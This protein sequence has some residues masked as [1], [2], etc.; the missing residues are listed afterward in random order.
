MDPG[1]AREALR[2]AALDEDEGAD[3]LMV[4]PALAY[5][6][7]IARVRAASTLPLGAYNV[8]G[9]Y[10]MIKAAA[11]GGHDRRAPRG[12]RA[13]HVDPARRRRLHPD[14]P[15]DRRRSAFIDDAPRPA[16]R[17]TS[18]AFSASVARGFGLGADD[19]G[20]GLRGDL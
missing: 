10:A 9:E 12:A 20:L 14:V 6:D 3:M 17:M 2:E 7:V 11:R 1:N 16:G 13:A 8:S 4:K 19:V 15:C 5:L 18:L